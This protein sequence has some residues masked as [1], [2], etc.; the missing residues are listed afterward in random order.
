[1]STREPRKLTGL[2]ANA[3]LGAVESHG[4]EARWGAFRQ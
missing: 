4:A 1:M 2:F 3:E